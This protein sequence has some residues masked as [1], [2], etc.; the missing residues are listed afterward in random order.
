M[1]YIQPPLPLQIPL[2]QKPIYPSIH[3]FHGIGA[4]DNITV[5]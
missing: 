5:F 4:E 3:L 1:N 2:Y